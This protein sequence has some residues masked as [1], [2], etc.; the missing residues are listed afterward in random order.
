MLLLETG[1]KLLQEDGVYRLLT[2]SE[3]APW[4][5]DVNTVNFGNYA[6]APRTNIAAFDPD[7]GP[8]KTRRRMSISSDQLTFLLYMTTA[9]K[10]SFKAFF[11]NTIA[12][13]TLPFLFPLPDTGLTTTLNFDNQSP[14]QIRFTDYNLWEVTLTVRTNAT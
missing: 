5:P 8:A 13:G 10:T 7:V 12:D 9:E 3:T 11:K 1:D 6:E 2:E 4:P 14:Y